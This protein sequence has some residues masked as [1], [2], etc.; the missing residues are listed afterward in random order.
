MRPSG[1]KCLPSAVYS[2]IY[3]YDHHLYYHHKNIIWALC[4][5][6]GSGVWHCG[7]AVSP[8]ASVHL[9][10]NPLGHWANIHYMPSD[11]CLERMLRPRW[12]QLESSAQ[13]SWH[14]WLVNR[15]AASGSWKAGRVMAIIWTFAHQNFC[16]FL[17][18]NQKMP[19]LSDLVLKIH[20]L[21][22]WS[23]SPLLSCNIYF[24]LKIFFLITYPYKYRYS[25]NFLL[26][27][28]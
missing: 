7:C 9:S 5:F 10:A 12:P 1:G 20:M 27:C 16:C 18:G 25:F 15:S 19:S 14:H 11:V 13:G 17:T 22:F 28:F 8:L 26:L 23:L 6:P 3:I 2:Q 4:T 24:L 21:C